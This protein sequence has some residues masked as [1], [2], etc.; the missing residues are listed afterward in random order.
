MKG[1]PH[2]HNNSRLQMVF[3]YP[4]VSGFVNNA[5]GI[6]LNIEQISNKLIAIPIY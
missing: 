1:E 2:W 4:M 3:Y 5:N 6:K